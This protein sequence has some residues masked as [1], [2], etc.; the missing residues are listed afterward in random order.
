MY[1]TAEGIVMHY[2]SDQFVARNS[3]SLSMFS[4][5]DFA[6]NL[7]SLNTAGLFLYENLRKSAGASVLK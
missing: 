2:G 1:K 6:D 7:P 5:L 4:H 3:G